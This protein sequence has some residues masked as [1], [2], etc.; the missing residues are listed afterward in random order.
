MPCAKGYTPPPLL[1]P[2]PAT[3]GQAPPPPGPTLIDPGGFVWNDLHDPNRGRTGY[4]Q[5]EDGSWVPLSFYSGKPN[6]GA[7]R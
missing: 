1:P 3:P 4:T 6:P 2:T 5:A 7:G